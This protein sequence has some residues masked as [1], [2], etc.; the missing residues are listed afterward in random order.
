MKSV[1][2]LG[3]C[4]VEIAEYPMPEP[5]ENE[6]LVKVTASGVCGGEMHSFRGP[7]AMDM[8]GGHEVAGI[9]A[10]PHG[11]P[12]WEEG[13]RVG[14]FTLGGCGK[15]R[16]CRQGRDTFCAEVGTPRACHSEYIAVKA[17]AMVKLC[18]DVS[19]S[20][21]VL[22]CGDGLGGPMAGRSAPAWAR[23]MSRACSAAGRLASGWC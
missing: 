11:H 19:A 17:N 23:A 18:D 4:K 3:N 13:E 20:V 5:K 7:N 15:C 6:V 21:A 14:I 10:D 2:I 22:L 1:H 12:Q 9:I 16:W 8:N